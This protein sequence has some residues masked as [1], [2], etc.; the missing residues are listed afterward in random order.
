MRDFSRMVFLW[1]AR[2]AFELGD[3]SS[4]PARQGEWLA[5]GKGVGRKAES[6]GSPRQNVGPTNSNLI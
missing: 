1:C 6:E 2:H 4:P 3:E 5:D